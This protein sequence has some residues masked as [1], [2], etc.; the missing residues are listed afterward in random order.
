MAGKPY[1]V[2]NK[3]GAGPYGVVA[4]NLKELVQEG[5]KKLQLSE[6]GCRVC[7]Y[8]DGTEVDERYFLALDNNCKLVILQKGQ[9][10]KGEKFNILDT[11]VDFF[12]DDNVALA[13]LANKQLAVESLPKK[14]KLLESFIPEYEENIAAENREDDPKWFEGVDA[15][16]KT[17]SQFMRNNCAARMRNYLP[18]RFFEPKHSDLDEQM[19]DACNEFREKITDK[20]RKNKYN[21]SYFDRTDK[22]NQLCDENGLFTCQGAFNKTYCVDGHLINPYACKKYRM[23]FRTWNFDHKIEKSDIISDIVKAVKNNDT[24]DTK[25]SQFYKNL[26]TMTN[27]KFVHNSCHILTKHNID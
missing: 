1:R 5:C 19:K 20:L 27:L 12:H 24:D 3:S 13:E 25:V 8:E 18:R 10:W 2:T 23:F 17:K 14:R 9:E 26:F 16:Y 4:S 22:K 6:D 7:L 21:E 11:F 15:Q